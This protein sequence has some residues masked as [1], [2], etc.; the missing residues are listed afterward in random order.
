MGGTLAEVINFYIYIASKRD[1]NKSNAD[2]MEQLQ[3]MVSLKISA[4]KSSYKKRATISEIVLL[5]SDTEL[6]YCLI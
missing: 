3:R 5:E 2:K 4:L 6:D 1:V